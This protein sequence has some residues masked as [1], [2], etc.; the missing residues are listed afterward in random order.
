MEHLA[1]RHSALEWVTEQ[2]MANALMHEPESEAEK[3]LASLSKKDGRAW[4]NTQG[5]SERP[6]PTREQLFYEQVEHLVAKIRT[7]VQQ[8]RRK[9]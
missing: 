8:G 7:R 1:A 2:H 9:A 5:I 6:T 3:F 4:N